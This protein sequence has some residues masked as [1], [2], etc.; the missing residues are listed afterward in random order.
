MGQ[1]SHKIIRGGHAHISFPQKQRSKK[2]RI[3]HT[4]TLES[5]DIEHILMIGIPHG[6]HEAIALRLDLQLALTQLGRMF[7]RQ[8]QRQPGA[9]ENVNS[10]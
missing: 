3:S 5:H 7:L 9:I 10:R 2:Q 4:R 6:V 1:R 8:T